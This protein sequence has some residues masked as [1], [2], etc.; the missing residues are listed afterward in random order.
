MPGSDSSQEEIR[1]PERFRI[2]II[3]RA[4]AGKTTILRAVC[5]AEG[6]PDVYD[7]DGS[8]ITPEV[9]PGGVPDAPRAENED[10]HDAA[11]AES[12]EVM[13]G[14]THSASRTTF[15]AN[16]RT[17][18]RTIRARIMCR[19]SDSVLASEPSNLPP[20]LHPGETRNLIFAPHSVLIPD[21]PIGPNLAAP[22]PYSQDN[23]NSILAPSALRGEHNVEYSLEFP[24]NPSFVFH[25]SRGFE[26]G[27]TDELELVRKFIQDK[28]TLG[29][30]K[31]QLHAIWYCFSTDSNRFMT[32]AD[33]EFFD[34]IDTGIVPVIA[35][36][37]KF[38]ALD[39]VAFSA[40]EAQGVPFEEAR[41][42]APEHAQANFDNNLLPLIKN[43]AHPPRAVACLRNMH[44]K[45]S[46]D[47][48]QKAASELVERTEAAL[49]NDALKV[50]LVQAQRINVELCMKGAVNSGVITKAAQDAFQQN[51]ATF[52]PLQSKLIGEIFQWFPSIWNAWTDP[53]IEA[54]TPH[55][56]PH[57]QSMPPALQIISVG[58]AAVII[59]AKAFW[60]H[61]GYTRVPQITAASQH[62]FQS[63]TAEHVRV[64]ILE[65]FKGA[66]V[67]YDTPESIAALEQ[68][69]LKN[70]MSIPHPTSVM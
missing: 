2:L 10:V 19:P 53:F 13:P 59:A 55:I 5:G 23:P 50:L 34:T 47:A 40:L 69:V 58:C 3:G 68:V 12:G 51:P 14:S 38:D 29:S 31:N 52:H 45:G 24:S 20:S 42:R 22:L 66:P 56:T 32:A 37:T 21:L 17:T 63:T 46:P 33:K 70:Q 65:A 57:L 4:N 6:E 7:R 49:D 9:H 30:M 1:R 39:S 44:N 27:A 67:L 61:S 15:R 54:A 18:L 11:L 26:S 25:D 35:I 28:A 43:V 16:L 48:I 62:Y 36:F 64:A 8:K 41:K 60:L